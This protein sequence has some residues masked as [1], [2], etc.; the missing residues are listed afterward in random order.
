MT[1]I[2]FTPKLILVSLVSFLVSLVILIGIWFALNGSMLTTKRKL[3]VEVKGLTTT[4]SSLKIE[5]QQL[6]KQKKLV[7]S[8]VV[9]NKPH[10]PNGM[11]IG[12]F[13]TDLERFVTETNMVI[14]ATEY[15][16]TMVY[17]AAGNNNTNT[18]ASAQSSLFKLE[19]NFEVRGG[20]AEDCQK[21]IDRLENQTRYVNVTKLTY[22]GSPK[23]SEYTVSMTFTTY[24]LSEYDT[25][26]QL[27]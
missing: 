6:S 21:L 25:F 19:S 3:D 27:S 1:K 24:Y 12:E 17:P 8:V 11:Q 5:N 16:P 20:S 23:D 10:I 22:N 2:Q 14:N 18:P 26:K 7:D 15:T 13:L 9:K 4:I